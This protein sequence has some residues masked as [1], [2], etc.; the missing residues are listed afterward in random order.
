M[1]LLDNLYTVL[2]TTQNSYKI[3]LT[4]ENHPVFK[5]HFPNM[6]ILPG[7]LQIDIAQQLLNTSFTKLNKAK[8]IKPVEPNAILDYV[9]KNNKIIIKNDTLKISEFTYE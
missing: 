4:N 7:F 6:P 3:Q 1:H 9:C 8:F 5:A 2:E